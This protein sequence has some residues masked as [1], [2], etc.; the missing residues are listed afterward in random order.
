MGVDPARFGDDRTAIVRRQTR[1]VFG[2]ES[3]AKIDT[4]ETTGKIVK[5]INEEKPEMVFVD[6]GGLGAGV[7]DRLRELG[8]WYGSG[9]RRERWRE[10]FER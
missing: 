5:I 8:L 1:K 7:I 10:A 3:Y 4:M 9:D 2:I 6:V